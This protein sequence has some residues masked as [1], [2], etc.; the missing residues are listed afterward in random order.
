MKNSI[1]FLLTFLL[2]GI[3]ILLSGGSVMAQ[4]TGDY[5]SV[6]SGDWNATSTWNIWN[7][8]SWVAATAVPDS[9]VTTPGSNVV[10]ILSGHN[11]TFTA[12]DTI[13][14]LVVAEGG[15]LTFSGNG[16]S[17]VLYVAAPGITINGTLTINGNVNTA[18]PYGITNLAGTMT[19]GSTGVVNINETAAATGTKG[20]LPT[21]TWATGSTL[22][23][24]SIGGT[25]TTGWGSGGSQDFANINY[26]VTYGATGNFG[27]GFGIGKVVSG[28]FTVMATNDGV[29]T[30][31]LQLFGGSSGSVR[32]NGD[33]L[34]TGGYLTGSGTGSSSTLDTVFVMGNFKV[35]TGGS[36]GGFAVDRGSHGSANDHSGV[37]W[38]L[39]GDSV[40]IATASTNSG[41]LGNSNSQNST[42]PYYLDSRFVFAKSGTQYAKIKPTNCTSA[43]GLNFD[44]INGAQVNI[45]DTSFVI[46]LR[47]I[48]G[49]IIS[50]GAPLLSGWYTGSG[51][52]SGT[53][54]DSSSL[55]VDGK[56]GFLVATVSPV[57][58]T[59]PIGSGTAYRPVTLSLTPSAATLT[60][61]TAEV[62]DSSAAAL[63]NAGWSSPEPFS[64]VS[65]VR[66]YIIRSS[67][68]SAYTNSSLKIFYGADDQVQT[69][70]D[71]RI[72]QGPG[73]SGSWLD[74]GGSG[75]GTG[76]IAL[77]TITSTTALTNLRTDT[78]FALATVANDNPILGVVATNGTGG[79]DWNK[80]ATWNGGVLPDS[81]NDVLIASNDSV[82]VTST[83]AASCKGLTI[84]SK[85]KL[86]VTAPLIVK[87]AIATQ[88]NAW[89]Y[90]S[91]S[92]LPSFPLAASYNIDTASYYVHTSAANA[93]LGMAGYD[94]TFGN[95][96]VQ[97]GG[98][99]A[100][101][102]LTINGNLTVQTPSDEFFS[103]AGTNSLVHH[104]HGNVYVL[105]GV[106]SC[107]DSNGSNTVT[108]IW[109]VDSNVT[110]SKGAVAPFSSG[111]AA[112]NRIGI[113]NIK[114]ILLLENGAQLEAGTSASS[115]LMTETGII[116]LSGGLTVV[117]SSVIFGTNSKGLFA[118]NFVGNGNQL[119]SLGKPMLFSSSSMP[120]TLNDTVAASSNVILSGSKSWA[121]T[122]AGAANGGG[123]F[124][125]NGILTLGAAD[126]IKGLQAFALDSGAT[127]ATANPNGIS[128]SGGIQVTGAK[129][130]STKANYVYDGTT[131]AQVTGSDLP[132]T[133]NRLTVVNYAGVTLSKNLTLTDSLRIPS[134]VLH[135]GPDTL[136]LP[137]VIS[138]SSTNYIVTDSTGV[139]KI[140][141]VGSK[142]A[143][144]PIGTKTNYAPVWI[145]NSGTADAFYVSVS[146]DTTKTTN[147]LGRVDVKW[148]IAEGTAGGSN[149]T[150]QF[151]WMATEEDSVF[152]HNRTSYSTIYLVTDTS[153]TESGSG[154]Y[155][156]Q[157]SNQPY[158]VSRGGITV[159][160]DFVVGHFTMTGVDGQETVPAV[161]KLYQNY[162]NPFN[163]STMI[164]FTVAKRGN[165]TLKVYNVLG[166]QVLTLFD[167]EAQPG[168]KYMARFDGGMLP[169]G[170]YFN[171]LEST[172]QREIHKMVLIK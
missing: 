136:T 90:N 14:N 28:N 100:G 119:V 57:T 138:P 128:P 155:T 30:G 153:A 115:T 62:I 9:A 66:Y 104:V 84:Q 51:L 130:Y 117:D 135:L 70:G 60:T 160:G 78:V 86:N 172:G 85:A 96:I 122:S 77:D 156:T 92:N 46:Y 159:F 31:R 18:A 1:D 61:Y 52:Y 19:V 164:E 8:S 82:I 5:Q 40:V 110:V 124:V 15:T 123:A 36:T 65:R 121:S 58:K 98:T 127:I 137:G 53:I 133:I 7:G 165:A 151:G 42:Y 108:G 97:R 43:N 17:P 59:F 102:N 114:G 158:T 13:S 21:A 169:S 105:G 163:P 111:S 89:F 140:I 126:T 147:G 144:F 50:R 63:G 11:V 75:T 64:H 83:M 56:L 146:P 45:A 129:S 113:F 116:N 2:V 170:V 29:K 41:N 161:F 26:D 93:S 22:N 132:S 109:N 34:V 12:T 48:N 47:L 68:D 16:A 23:V 94:S 4:N 107:V 118:I 141:S 91:N 24:N 145:T 25:G 27:W 143:M 134:G 162:P 35:T 149:C 79:G 106:W 152:A 6:A 33:L 81:T 49:K 44:I 88:P 167:D 76:T 74:L 3:F 120:V 142:L 71:L 80:P 32:I 125:V 148:R 95:V 38:Y 69:P 171:V 139:V 99:T 157:F 67:S 154:S 112:G 103:G 168:K 54:E 150:L 37:V 55:F 101:A 166:Q 72:A 20:F 87:G 10:T 73:G 39:Y 131:T